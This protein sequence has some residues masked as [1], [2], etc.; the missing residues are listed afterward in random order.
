MV[1]NECH[2]Y[3]YKLIRER[4]KERERI[5]RDRGRDKDSEREQEERNRKIDMVT[6]PHSTTVYNTTKYCTILHSN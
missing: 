2:V 1:E 3:L 5:D 6:A 4:G